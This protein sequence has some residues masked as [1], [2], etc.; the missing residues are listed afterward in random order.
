MQALRERVRTV[1]ADGHLE[2]YKMTTHFDAK[3]GRQQHDY[4]TLKEL[5]L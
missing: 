5:P 2:L 1:A 4:P 3:V